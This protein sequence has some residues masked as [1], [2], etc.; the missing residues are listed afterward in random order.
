MTQFREALELWRDWRFP[1][2]A[3]WNNWHP[4]SL[5]TIDTAPTTPGAYVLG[6]PPGP[7]LGRLLALDPH[8]LLD[9][10]ESGNLR[11]RLANLRACA[12][13]AGRP[14]HMAGWRLGS[15]GLLDRLAA[16]VDDLRVSWCATRTKEEAY[17]AEGRML[18]LYFDIF[19]E[20]APLNYKFNWSGLIEGP[21]E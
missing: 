9:I 5:A 7:P 12:S 6:L 10:G 2:G 17:A 1:S 18:R 15:M 16:T 3:D 8:R 11:N 20:L 4:L 19:G 13:T 21:S 14:G